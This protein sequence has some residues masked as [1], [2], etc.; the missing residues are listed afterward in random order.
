MCGVSTVEVIKVE[1]SREGL[2]GVGI[3]DGREREEKV[4]EGKY[5]REV[6][7]CVDIVIKPV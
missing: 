6:V 5:V 3:N 7:G 1:V 4:G 2:N